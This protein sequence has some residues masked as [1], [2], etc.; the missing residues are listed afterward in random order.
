M[1]FL[2]IVLI[3]SFSPPT[4]S[5]KFG[6]ESPYNHQIIPSWREMC[7]SLTSCHLATWQGPRENCAKF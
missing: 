7:Q 1:H 4:P 5:T 3:Y 2:Y 6:S